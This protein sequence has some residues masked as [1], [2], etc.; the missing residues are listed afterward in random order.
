MF[1]GAPFTMDRQKLTGQATS[2]NVEICHPLS[3][4]SCQDPV[5]ILHVFRTRAK[6]ANPL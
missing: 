2:E 5:P 4:P 3:H 1:K 6:E